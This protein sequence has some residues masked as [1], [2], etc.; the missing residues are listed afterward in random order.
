MITVDY[1][2]VAAVEY[3]KKWALSRNPAYYDF[4]DLGGDCTNYASQCLY[5]GSGQMNFTPVFGW[6]YISAN[7]RTAS[8]TG[9]EFF[10]NFLM[11]NSGLGPFADD[12]DLPQVEIGDFVQLGR[13]SGEFYH[14]PIVTGFDGDMPLV[15]AHTY[16]S[17]DRR[18][19]SY[20]YD[21]I[22]FIHILGVRKAR[23]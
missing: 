4:N 8:W 15:C 21:R 23:N 1:N 19:D 13:D 2:R 18:L 20:V 12:V 10:Y 17:L 11:S 22:R 14:T 3:A 9:V 5:A 16:D 7:E 6:Y